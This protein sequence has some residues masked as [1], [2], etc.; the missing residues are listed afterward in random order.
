MGCNSLHNPSGG[1]EDGRKIP[2]SHSHVHCVGSRGP[3]QGPNR[4]DVTRNKGR[5][6]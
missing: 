2:L 1:V 3:V 5:Q 6:F 4:V